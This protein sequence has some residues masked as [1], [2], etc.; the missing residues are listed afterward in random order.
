M[1]E[2]E[3]FSNYKELESRIQDVKYRLLLG[4]DSNS[5]KLEKN[6]AQLEVELLAIHHQLIN[7]P[8]HE[9]SLGAKR[10]MSHQLT[11]YIHAISNAK[12]GLMVSRNQHLMVKNYLFGK[13][14][15][16]LR[17]YLK[18]H[19]MEGVSVPDIDFTYDS[20]DGI[21]CE[22]FVRF[23]KEENRGLYELNPVDYISLSSFVDGFLSRIWKQFP[24]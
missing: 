6:M 11:A 24:I 5:D 17:F 13:I 9:N 16:D 12:S 18:H 19:G 2:F 7:F 20:E 10:G 14:T 3:L 21:E 8:N 22:K 4:S 23:L 15:S 1:S